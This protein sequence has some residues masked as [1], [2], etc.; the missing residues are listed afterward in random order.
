MLFES[1]I[2]QL[3]GIGPIGLEEIWV[4]AEAVSVEP[5]CTRVVK[6]VQKIMMFSGVNGASLELFI[7]D[8]II[9]WSDVSVHARL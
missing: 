4:S 3:L 9:L 8:H 6:V 2:G 7:M 5:I 1:L